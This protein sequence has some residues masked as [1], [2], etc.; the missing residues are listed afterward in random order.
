MPF[1]S[2]HAEVWDDTNMLIFLPCTCLCG[3]TGAAVTFSLQRQMGVNANIVNNTL[4]AL[5][6]KS[7]T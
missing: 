7:G 6:L 2:A 1:G 5:C 4:L 3:N